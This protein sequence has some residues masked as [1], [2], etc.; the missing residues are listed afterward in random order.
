M[1]EIGSIILELKELNNELKIRNEEIKKLR[2]RKK[3]IEENLCKFFEEKKQPGIKY[4][5]LAVVAEDKTAR[6][7][8]KKAEKTQDCINV[9]KHYNIHN[10]EK[11]YNEL[12]ETMKGDEISK[13][14]VKIISN[15]FNK[16]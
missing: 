13:K 7:K 10:A 3:Q 8:K 6:V 9:L 16:K 14:T 12:L 2:E 15:N 5:G 1:S 4:K 11:I